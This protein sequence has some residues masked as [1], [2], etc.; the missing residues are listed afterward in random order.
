MPSI[1]LRTLPSGTRNR[2]NAYKSGEVR[3]AL[4]GDA[5]QNVNVTKLLNLYSYLFTNETIDRLNYLYDFKEIRSVLSILDADPNHLSEE[6]VKF[7]S[8]LVTRP[9]VEDLGGLLIPGY[10]PIDYLCAVRYSVPLGRFD[11]NMLPEFDKMWYLVNSE[12]STFIKIFTIEKY[13]DVQ[14]MFQIVLHFLENNS[15]QDL[16]GVADIKIPPE[17]REMILITRNSK[18]KD[19]IKFL[20]RYYITAEVR[21]NIVGSLGSVIVVPGIH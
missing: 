21:R 15:L 8:L 17:Q 12:Y 3:Q 14:R 7:R 2:E 13:S 11:F 20:K 18:I 5:N 6:F 19:C 9:T 16:V 10:L 1:Y 4:L